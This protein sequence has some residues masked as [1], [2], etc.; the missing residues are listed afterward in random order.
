MF[1]VTLLWRQSNVMASR[2][3]DNFTI[4]STVCFRCTSKK[5]PKLC[6]AGLFLWGIHPWRVDSLQKGPVTRKIF[7][8]MP[9]SWLTRECEGIKEGHWRND[10]HKI[11]LQ[12]N[13]GTIFIYLQCGYFICRCL[14]T[15]LEARSWEMTLW[16][17][18]YKH[19]RKWWN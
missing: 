13:L 1:P 19:K 7:H 9:L 16:H 5:T 15:T 17:F 12:L 2:I 18:G 11:A 3:T 10:C 14:P 8:A 6:A 4:C